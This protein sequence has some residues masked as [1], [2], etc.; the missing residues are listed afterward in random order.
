VEVLLRALAVRVDTELVASLALAMAD[1]VKEQP[2][3]RDAAELRF[4]RAARLVLSRG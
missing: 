3:E 1:L 2:E 4:R